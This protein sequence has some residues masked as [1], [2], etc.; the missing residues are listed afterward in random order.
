MKSI[1]LLLTSIF[2]F[3][4]CAKTTLNS[5]IDNNNATEEVIEDVKKLEDECN[6]G[7]FYSCVLLGVFYDEVEQDYFKAKELYEKACNSGVG[8]GCNNLGL[9]YYNGYG[10]KQDYNKALDLFGKACELKEQKACDA[11]RKVKN[12]LGR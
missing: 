8:E 5:T 1:I 2:I 9:M 4:G 11:Y 7:D 6:K 10:V 3:V 12:A